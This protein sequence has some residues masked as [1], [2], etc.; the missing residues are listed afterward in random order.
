MLG[1][2]AAIGWATPSSLTTNEFTALLKIYY[3]VVFHKSFPFCVISP[4]FMQGSFLELKAHLCK[5]ATHHSIKASC[6]YWLWH[7]IWAKFSTTSSHVGR[8]MPYPEFIFASI[9]VWWNPF[10]HLWLVVNNRLPR[11][12]AWDKRTQ[13]AKTKPNHS[14]RCRQWR[15]ATQFALC[16]SIK[17]SNGH[18]FSYYR[19]NLSVTR[20]WIHPSRR[21]WHPLPLGNMA[22]VFSRIIRLHHQP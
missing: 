15:A 3:L 1:S 11:L 12:R 16:F 18:P 14:F 21:H 13:I 5:L 17:R 7:T 10:P 19:I 20:K 4:G 8:M 6:S 2:T 9:F 22:D